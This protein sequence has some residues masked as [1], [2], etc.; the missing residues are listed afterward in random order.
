MIPGVFQDAKWKE[1]F[2][3]LQ[4][5]G[6]ITQPFTALS[7]KGEDLEKLAEGETPSEVHDLLS[8]ADLRI[9][10]YILYTSTSQRALVA[11]HGRRSPRLVPPPN[12]HYIEIYI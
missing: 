6:V 8:E 4:A 10:I 9:E 3:K 12:H 5:E 11:K 7:P 1:L 2:L